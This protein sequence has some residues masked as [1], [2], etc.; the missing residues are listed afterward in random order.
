MSPYSVRQPNE[1][2]L[3][4]GVD[5]VRD[6]LVLSRLRRFWKDAIAVVKT[7]KQSVAVTLSLCGGSIGIDCHHVG[8]TPLKRLFV[9]AW[10]PF[11]MLQ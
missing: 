9:L 4:L 11:V 7:W 5:M 6:G 8:M 3:C 1:E 2:E 10:P